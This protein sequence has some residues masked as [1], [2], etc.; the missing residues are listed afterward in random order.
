[1]NSNYLCKENANRAQKQIYLIMPRYSLS[2]LMQRNK[3]SL[4]FPRSSCF[5]YEKLRKRKKRS[6]SQYYRPQYQRAKQSNKQRAKQCC[7]PKNNER[8]TVA[9]QKTTSEAMLRKPAA[10]ASFFYRKAQ[11]FFGALKTKSLSE[12]QRVLFV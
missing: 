12:R 4:F 5:L 2:S 10:P 7:A 1:M 3:F 9:P 6:G 11:V 8:S